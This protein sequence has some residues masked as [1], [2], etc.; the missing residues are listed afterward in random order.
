MV[1]TFL[2]AMIQMHKVCA[3]LFGCTCPYVLSSR[4]SKCTVRHLTSHSQRCGVNIHVVESVASTRERALQLCPCPHSRRNR[5]PCPSLRQEATAARRRR[6]AEAATH[7]RTAS[8]EADSSHRQGK[9][10]RRSAVRRRRGQGGRQEWD[11]AAAASMVATA[12]R[13]PAGPCRAS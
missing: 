5:C 10:R 2:N 1:D 6:Q 11:A 3:W 8:R 7:R 4:F 9:T 12:V 13:P